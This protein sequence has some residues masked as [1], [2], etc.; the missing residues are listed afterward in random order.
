VDDHVEAEREWILEDGSGEGVVD[1]GDEVVLFGE[2]DGFLKIDEADSG[3][4]GR[5]DVE[6][7][8]ERGKQAV[9]T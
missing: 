4:S 6:D 7:F 8:G 9:Q 3:V 1:D 2:G 5:F